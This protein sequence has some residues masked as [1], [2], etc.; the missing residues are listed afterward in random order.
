[1]H[2]RDQSPGIGITPEKYVRGATHQTGKTGLG[3]RHIH[4]LRGEI[5]S[6][7]G[8]CLGQGRVYNTNLSEQFGWRMHGPLVASLIALTLVA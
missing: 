4:C 8:V 3:N 1:M 6:I 5:E 7:A 2:V